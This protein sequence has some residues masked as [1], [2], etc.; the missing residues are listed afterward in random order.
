MIELERGWKAVLIGLVVIVAIMLGAQ[1][2][3]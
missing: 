3:W 2:P 1:V